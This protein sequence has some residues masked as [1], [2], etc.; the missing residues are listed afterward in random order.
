[1][2]RDDLLTKVVARVGEVKYSYEEY[3]E[4]SK[5]RKKEIEKIDFSTAK[6]Y[7]REDMSYRSTAIIEKYGTSVG[8]TVASC[9]FIFI[10]AMCVIACMPGI[11][12]AVDNLLGNFKK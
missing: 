1:M 10:I 4:L 5:E 9:V 7:I 2:S 3:K 12:Y 11:L 6:F 8:R